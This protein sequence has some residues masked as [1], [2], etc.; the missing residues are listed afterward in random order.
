M[1]RPLAPLCR[2]ACERPLPV[3]RLRPSFGQMSPGIRSRSAF[4]VSHRL[5]GFLHSYVAGLLRPATSSRF[6]VFPSGR[7]R[8]RRSQVASAFPTM[9]IPL[10][11]FSSSIAVPHHCGLCLPAVLPSPALLRVARPE[12]RMRDPG[13]DLGSAPLSTAKSRFPVS[14]CGS[15]AGCASA[16]RVPSWELPPG[17]GHD[18][19][20]A[21]RLRV[22]LAGHRFLQP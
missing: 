20:F 17:A 7:P 10:E 12:A 18:C 16:T 2:F 4:T 9:L 19:G 3:G 5:D 13:S 22:V 21:S 15:W 6:I 1:L 14:P 11:G 8:T